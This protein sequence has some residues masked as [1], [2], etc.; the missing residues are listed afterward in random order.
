MQQSF[1]NYPERVSLLKISLP[2]P[3]KFIKLLSFY[4]RYEKVQH[5]VGLKY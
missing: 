1:F 3:E 2:S 5:H 4:T